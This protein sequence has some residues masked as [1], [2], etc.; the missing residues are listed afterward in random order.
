MGGII[1]D[2]ACKGTLQRVRWVED[3]AYPITCLPNPCLVRSW[4]R[5]ISVLS[6]QTKREDGGLGER[7]QSWAS[8]KF[9]QRGSILKVTTVLPHGGGCCSE[10]GAGVGSEPQEGPAYTTPC[11]SR[12]LS[13]SLVVS[14]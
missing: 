11:E 6:L 3:P 13:S 7:G 12:S 2:A 9:P 8:S 14:G 1:G 5:E 4:V 10:E